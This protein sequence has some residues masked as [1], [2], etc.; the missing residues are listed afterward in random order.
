MRVVL[1]AALAAAMLSGCAGGPDRNAILQELNPAP[2]SQRDW[3]LARGTYTGPVRST[4]QRF[5]VEGQSAT[6]MR[7]DL[8]GWADQPGIKARMDAGYSTAWSMY[9]ERKGVY[10]NI[11]AQRYGSQGTVY[12]STHAPNILLLKFRRYGA[13]GNTGTWMI[14]TFRGNGA[15]DVDLIG[16]SGWRGDGE[17]WRIPATERH[18]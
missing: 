13:S 12:P 8:S 11:P 5:G 6:E 1:L 16:H 2:M 4:T 9:G 18:Q 3:A 10:T 17:L 15:I 14:L 7:L